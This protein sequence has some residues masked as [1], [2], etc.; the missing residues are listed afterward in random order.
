MNIR[1]TC[2]IILMVIGLRNAEAQ[3]RV[4]KFFLGYETLEMSMNNFK[5]FAGEIGYRFNLE[6]QVR[7][8]VGEVR[9]TERHLS[10]KWE[11]AAVDGDNVQG[12]FRIYELSY[13]KFFGKRKNWYVSGSMAYVNDQYEHMIMDEMKI[14][15]HTPTM[16]FGIGYQQMDLFGIEHLYIN[17]SIP[18]RYYLMGIEEQQWGATTIHK[19][20]LVNNFWFFVGFNL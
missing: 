11:S 2:M 3:K 17:V 1:L 10:S 19:H 4:G 5:H 7:L 16:G 14:D 20:E 12:Y 6:D 18:F 13:D 9:L 8:M 15:N